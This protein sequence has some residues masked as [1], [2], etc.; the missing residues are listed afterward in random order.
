MNLI[1]IGV[2]PI[3]SFYRVFFLLELVFGP[4]PRWFLD[5]YLVLPSF[6]YLIQVF[7][8]DLDWFL[9]TCLVLLSFFKLVLGFFNHI[10]IGLWTLT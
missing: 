6:F 1:Q 8:L 4:N 9:D 3:P 10:Q 2:G 5:D 7:G